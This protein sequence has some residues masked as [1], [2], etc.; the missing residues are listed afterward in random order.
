[1]LKR[2]DRSSGRRLRSLPE[3][4]GTEVGRFCSVRPPRYSEGDEAKTTGRFALRTVVRQLLGRVGNTLGEPLDGKAE[5]Q[6]QKPLSAWRRGCPRSD[7]RRS[8]NHVQ[9]GTWRLT[10]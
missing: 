8:V 7:Q 6:I 3:P 1:M 5:C 4:R 9:H 10:R 2:D